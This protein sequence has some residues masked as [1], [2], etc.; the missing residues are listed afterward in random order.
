MHIAE[1]VLSAPALVGGA[2]VAA[3][4][5]A[6]GLRGMD[7]RRTIQV[8]VLSSAL[9]V[10]SLIHVPAGPA[11]VH[12]V[13][14]GLAG[15]VLG[16]A[17]FPATLT[18][19]LMQAVFFGYGGLTTL[20]VNTVVMAA[21]GVVCHYAFRRG[22]ASASTRAAFGIGT[23]AGALSVLGAALLLCLTLAGEGQSF[24]AAAALVFAA[25]VPV[26]IVEALVCGSVVSFLRQVRPETFAMPKPAVMY[27][28]PNVE[29]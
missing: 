29:Y 22:L 3:G 16:W 12:L 24:A 13:L 9:F 17:V 8:A 23:A 18:A 25:H 11:Q 21:P 4:A 27:L 6:L 7:D 28:D 10:A 20:G 19:L 15:L 2:A 5:T 14:N 1:G 26:A